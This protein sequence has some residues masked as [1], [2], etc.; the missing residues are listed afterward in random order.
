MV[1]SR[2]PQCLLESKTKV[3]SPYRTSMGNGWAIVGQMIAFQAVPAHM[4]LGRRQQAPPPCFRGLASRGATVCTSPSAV[5]RGLFARTETPRREI[6]A[7]AGRLTQALGCFRAA[8][9]QV[10]RRHVPRLQRESRVLALDG[11][12]LDRGPQDR[13]VLPAAE[14]CEVSH[15]EEPCCYESW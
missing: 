7:D 6:M 12:A 4:D 9:D 5:H 1:R 11:K 10:N 2:T 8:H 13:E 14:G 3:A 15:R